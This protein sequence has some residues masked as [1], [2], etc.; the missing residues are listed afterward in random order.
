MENKDK[1]LEAGDGMMKDNNTGPQESEAQIRREVDSV[2][3]FEH[4]GHDGLIQKDNEPTPTPLKNEVSDL[5]GSNYSDD[6][7]EIINK[8]SNSSE[9][10]VIDVFDKIHQLEE[11]TKDKESSLMDS[12]LVS[13]MSDFPKF[14]NEKEALDDYFVDTAFDSKQD[15]KNNDLLSQTGIKS[16]TYDFMEAERGKPDTYISNQSHLE[17]ESHT[18]DKSP[19]KEAPAKES[20]SSVENLLTDDFRDVDEEFHSSFE[21]SKESKEQ[22]KISDE[23]STNFPKKLQ[24][25][26]PIEVVKT[27]PAEELIVKPH[28]KETKV[29]EK[30][31]I[32]KEK[33][34]VRD[35]SKNVIEA[36]ILFSKMGLE[37]H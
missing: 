30:S 11:N 35:K 27:I 29:E 3:D 19:K 22:V 2:D 31:A 20:F 28:F 10:A 15:F 24:E 16:T 12:N 33:E 18:F 9:G 14:Q 13:K 7:Q 32:P 21:Q 25:A 34:M 23:L 17:S 6:L 5:L 26:S 37:V 8:G 36:E 1:I 4:L